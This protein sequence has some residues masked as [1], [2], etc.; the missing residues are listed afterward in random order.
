VTT[1]RA[2]LV[3]ARDRLRAA[4]IDDA[5]IEAEVLLRYALEGAESAKDAAPARPA[6]ASGRAISRP[7]L[8]MRFEDEATAKVA[9]AYRG[10]LARRLAHEPSAHI[11]GR[12]EFWGLEFAVTPAVLIPRPETEGLVEAVL[13]ELAALRLVQDTSTARPANASE[14]AVRV[15][16]RLRIAD[17]GTGSGAIAVALALE[18][19]GAEVYALDASWEALDVAAGNARRHGVARRLALRHGDLLTPLHDYVDCVVANLPYVTTGEWAGLQPEVREHEPRQAL[20]GGDDGL[21]LIRAL[22]HQAPRYLL[23]GGFV[24]LEIGETHAA[25]LGRFVEQIWPGATWRVEQDFA[26]KD[27]Y[28]FVRPRR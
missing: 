7:E 17:V 9:E 8:Y 28:F 20:D 5:Q 25:P 10:F 4:G 13:R 11:T 12:R 18:L 23:P 3:A 27:R 14:R 16:G 6:R 1:L 21:D 15:T 26:G 19:P 2:A 24:A 22:L